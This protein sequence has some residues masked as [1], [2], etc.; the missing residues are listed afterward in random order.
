VLV[1]LVKDT[2]AV[3]AVTDTQ[4]VA[5]AELDKLV[6][7]VLDLLEVVVMAFLALLMEQLLIMLV[8]ALD[9]VEQAD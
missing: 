2:L 8:V 1:L 4:V 6:L 7:L 3:R 5:E 9:M